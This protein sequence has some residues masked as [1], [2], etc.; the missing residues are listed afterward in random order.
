VWTAVLG[1]MVVSL[2]LEC[3]ALTRDLPY[4]DVDEPTFVRAAVHIVS[5][6]DLDPHWFGH[7]GST[8]IYPIAGL[9]HAWD[10]T[11]HGA[12]VFAANPDLAARFQASPT[13]FYV[14][15]RLWSI[16]FAVAAIPLVFL[17]GRR[18]FSTTVGLAGAAVWALLPIVVSYG[19]EV[20]TDSA[21]VFFALLAL[22]LIM[23]VVERPTRPNQVL[24]GVALGAGIA[25]RYF[26]VTFLPALVAASVIALRRR[27]PGASL[28]GIFAAVGA[29]IA[30]FALT[31]PYFFLDWTTAQQTLAVE[32]G[33]SLGHDGLSPVGNLR[34]Y[35]GLSLPKSLTWPI[36]LLA[37]AGVVL[38]LR[39]PRDVRRL[40]LLGTAVAFILAISTSKL[41]WERWPLPILPILVLL[42][43]HALVRLASA[44]HDHAVQPISGP[45]LAAAAVALVAISP[46]ASIVQLNLRESK[47]STRVLAGRWIEE[48]IPE[49]SSV[50]REL[51]TA[52]LHDPDLHVLATYSLPGNGWTLARYRREG[53]RYFVV[54]AAIN[55][56]YLSQPHRYPNQ[57]ALY[58]ELRRHACLLHKFR[59]GSNRWGPLIRIYQLPAAGTGCPLATR[60]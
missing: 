47:P 27:V 33:H 28:R 20:R 51:K 14:I 58:H 52:P 3:W 40:L 19:R 25:S 5:T 29:T 60:A 4:P 54:N 21:G 49:G 18:C 48:H 23:R 56:A 55:S 46:A 59:A 42:G 11:A 13:A 34:W 30:T 31:T 50:V 12:P 45:A 37:L 36:A 1:I 53:Y 15:G 44:V 8:T 57:A 38:V 35:L 10:V 9:Y 22:L 2:G 39:H 17:L 43:M 7:P 26:L 16:A 32:N 6:G 41:H 24:A